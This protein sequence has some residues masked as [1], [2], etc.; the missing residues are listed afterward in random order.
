MMKRRAPLKTIFGHWTRRRFLPESLAVY[1]QDVTE[2][3]SQWWKGEDTYLFLMSY[4]AF[5][6]MV[7]TFIA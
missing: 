5:F 7:M 3:D 1:P 4:G 2:P 6:T